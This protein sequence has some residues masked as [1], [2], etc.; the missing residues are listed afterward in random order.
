[1]KGRFRLTEISFA[2]AAGAYGVVIGPAGS[3]KTT[4]LEVLAGLVPVR[5]GR[6]PSPLDAIETD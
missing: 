6:H 5:E 2:L 4:L 1:M 3:G